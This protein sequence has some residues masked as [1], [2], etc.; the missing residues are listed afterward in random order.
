ML[1]KEYWIKWGQKAGIRAAKTIAQGL[2][3]GIG[4]STAM[5]EIDWLYVGS[6]AVLAGFI[7]L[8]T[9]IKGLPELDFNE[10]QDKVE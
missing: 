10:A 7:S 4:V 9:S 6:T 8:L 5:G 1:K 2:I 3:A